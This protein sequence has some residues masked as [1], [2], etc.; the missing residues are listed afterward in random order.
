MIEV[1]EEINHDLSEILSRVS[2]NYYQPIEILTFQIASE[3][4]SEE[5]HVDHPQISVQ[6]I[7]RQVEFYNNIKDTV[8]AYRKDLIEKINNFIQFVKDRISHVG[9]INSGPVVSFMKI[10]ENE[11]TSKFYLVKQDL[12]ACKDKLYVLA[13]KIQ[14]FNFSIKNVLAGLKEAASNSKRLPGQTNDEFKA[15]KAEQFK[16]NQECFN[17]CLV[18]IQ[19]IDKEFLNAKHAWDS[20]RSHLAEKLQIFDALR[21]GIKV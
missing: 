20:V 10:K 16:E 18:K 11:V 8:F 14:D 2:Y 9:L 6:D 12:I 19:Q 17:N 3:I 4:L 5:H 1:T 21:D 13:N 7:D 15:K